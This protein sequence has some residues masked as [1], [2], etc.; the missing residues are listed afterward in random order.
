MASHRQGV[1]G[2]LLQLDASDKLFL[3]ITKNEISSSD[4]AADV[5]REA[6]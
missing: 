4:G 6:H 3:S 1:G 2:R 5:V